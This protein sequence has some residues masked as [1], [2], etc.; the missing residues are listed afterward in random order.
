[1][2]GNTHAGNHKKEYHIKCFR[3]KNSPKSRAETVADEV[4]KQRITAAAPC[5]HIEKLFTL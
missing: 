3:R 1:M 5:H 4:R 2:E